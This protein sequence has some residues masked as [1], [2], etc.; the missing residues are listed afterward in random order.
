MGIRIDYLKFLLENTE[1]PKAK[2]LELGNQ[3][4]KDGCGGQHK[5]GK[6]LFCSMGCYHMSIDTNGRDGA[7][8]YD[9]GKKITDFDNEF[10]IITDFGTSI[11]VKNY[12][13]CYNNIYRMCKPGGV[14]VYVLPEENS[15]WKA[16]YYVNKK[17]FRN[18]AKKQGCKVKTTKI[19]K[20]LHGNLV[21]AAL[22]KDEPI[23]Q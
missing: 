13:M 15:N 22:V 19:I 7:M 6:A 5:T 17:F 3:I 1:I 4:I 2:L 11:C 12:K 23:Q 9:L 18:L 10:D 8:V 20:G 16:N 21:C 14:M